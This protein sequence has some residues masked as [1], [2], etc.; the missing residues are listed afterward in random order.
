MPD[1]QI[2]PREKRIKHFQ[3]DCPSEV[4]FSDWQPNNRV[5]TKQLIMKNVSKQSLTLTYKL[6]ELA[7]FFTPYPNQINLP[8]GMEYSI[9]VSFQPSAP[10]EL[11]SCL[12]FH[13]NQYNEDFK[14]QLRGDLPLLSAKTN[15]TPN[16]PVPTAVC[17][18]NF[19]DVPLKNDG[20]VP[21]LFKFVFSEEK[22]PFSVIPESG[23]INEGEQLM[24]RYWFKPE[25]SGQIQDTVQLTIKKV[26]LEAMAKVGKIDYQIRLNAISKFPHFRIKIDDIYNDQLSFINTTVIDEK[27]KEVYL[28]N[29][30]PVRASFRINA[31]T[32][33]DKPYSQVT[34]TP[35]SGIVEP[36]EKV[37]LKVTYRP[38]FAAAFYQVAGETLGPQDGSAEYSEAQTFIQYNPQDMNIKMK[39]QILAKSV[40][41]TTFQVVCSG[42]PVDIQISHT[43][44]DLGC[45]LCG[46]SA[47]KSIY[48]KNNSKSDCPYE[49]T[50]EGL[51]NQQGETPAAIVTTQSIEAVELDDVT[52]PTQR[53]LAKFPLKVTP[54]SGIAPSQINTTINISLNL[55]NFTC[56]SQD[57]LD[58]NSDKKSYIPPQPVSF[59]LQ[60]KTPGAPVQFI[61]VTGTILPEA[62]FDSRPAPLTMDYSERYDLLRREYTVDQ[63]LGQLVAS[64]GNPPLP[65]NSPLYDETLL[66]FET[67]YS[68]SQHLSTQALNKMI[69][70]YNYQDMESKPQAN[71]LLPSDALMLELKGKL[72]HCNK[73]PAVI[74]ERSYNFGYVAAGQEKKHI[75]TIYNTSE[76]LEMFCAFTGASHKQCISIEFLGLS[77]FDEVNSRAELTPSTLEQSHGLEYRTVLTKGMVVRIPPQTYGFFELTFSPDQNEEVYFTKFAV[78][79]CHQPLLLYRCFRHAIVGHS[80]IQ[81]LNVLGFSRPSELP[82]LTSS[83]PVVSKPVVDMNIKLPPAG[84]GSI[85]RTTFAFTNYGSTFMTVNL[86]ELT[87]NFVHVYPEV[88]GLEPKQTCVVSLALAFPM[89]ALTNKEKYGFTFLQQSQNSVM[90]EDIIIF[91]VNGSSESTVTL[92]MLA[93]CCGVD[94]V[95]EKVQEE[96]Q[97]IQQLHE[98]P[99]AT[100]QM[101]P[102]SLGSESSRILTFINKA[103]LPVQFYVNTTNQRDQQLMYMSPNDLLLSGCESKE[104][105]YV[106][107]ASEKFLKEG[108]YTFDLNVQVTIPKYYCLPTPNNLV[109]RALNYKHDLS[110]INAM[111]IQT[112]V[113]RRTVE[114]QPKT[115][116]L[117]NVVPYTS[118]D[119][120]IQIYNS[121]HCSI[122][123]TLEIHEIMN[124]MTPMEF[125]K[126]NKQLRKYPYTTATDTGDYLVPNLYNKL[127]NTE[128]VMDEQQTKRCPQIY[129][130]S[131]AGAMI[132]PHSSSQA[133][134]TVFPLSCRTVR[135]KIYAKIVEI[136]STDRKY[137]EVVKDLE[138]Q[139]VYLQGTVQAFNQYQN[140]DSDKM[141]E[142]RLECTADYPRFYISDISS[143]K[144]ASSQ[145][146]D[147]LNVD[148]INEFLAGEVSLEERVYSTP[149]NNRDKLIDKLL[150]DKE[151]K[152]FDS[153]N[154]FD[155]VSIHS[156]ARLDI[157]PVE[158]KDPATKFEL[159]EPPPENLDAEYKSKE[160][161]LLE[162][163][164]LVL[165]PDNLNP[166]KSYFVC[167]TLANPSDIP[168]H[169][170]FE[171]PNGPELGDCPWVQQLPSQAQQRTMSLLAR[172]IYSVSPQ[173]IYLKPHEKASLTINYAHI[174]EGIHKLIVLAKIAGGRSFFLHLIGSTLAEF[175]PALIAPIEQRLLP[176]ALGE[177]IPVRQ[178]M[179]IQ[180]PGNVYVRYQLVN[181]RLVF[182]QD[183]APDSSSIQQLSQADNLLKILNPTGIIPPE[184]GTQL[185]MQ[186]TPQQV[187]MVHMRFDL[188]IQRV[189]EQEFQSFKQTLKYFPGECNCDLPDESTNKQP[190]YAVNI[191]TVPDTQTYQQIDLFCYGFMK[192]SSVPTQVLP[193]FAKNGSPKAPACGA[194]SLQRVQNK[195]ENRLMGQRGL[196]FGELSCGR[197]VL[198]AVPTFGYSSALVELKCETG[199]IEWEVMD[200]FGG[201]SNLQ[202]K[203]EPNRGVLQKGQKTQILIQCFTGPLP[204]A[205]LEDIPFKI[206]NKRPQTQNVQFGSV[207][208][209]QNRLP[210]VLANTV[211]SAARISE[212]AILQQFD[213]SQQNRAG[214]DQETRQQHAM[215]YGVEDMVC[216]HKSGPLSQ[217][218]TYPDTDVLWLTVMLHSH[219]ADYLS[220]YGVLQNGLMLNRSAVQ[221]K[222]IIQKQ[223]IGSDLG[224]EEQQQL[225][226]LVALALRGAVN[227]MISDK[228]SE[229]KLNKAAARAK[230]D[231][232]NGLQKAN[233]FQ[234]EVEDYVQV[235]DGQK[236][237]VI[238]QAVGI[239]EF[240]SA[241]G[242]G[243]I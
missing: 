100:I 171:L 152:E 99:V 158:K 110:R 70:D 190:P 107:K 127:Y 40:V 195:S 206:I 227:K 52:R 68:Q 225:E 233:F 192:N 218:M 2:L 104:F 44:V 33:L 166:D 237:N 13:V 73:Y 116:N 77:Q 148:Q 122:C 67:E 135:A 9:T 118:V 96:Q 131:G 38:A 186:F 97:I 48:I 120:P 78:F 103:L 142:C 222:E 144:I 61:H 229:A 220:D 199:K 128:S 228:Q 75:V 174:E 205:F 146:R 6:P 54:C 181:Q 139:S 30:S 163:F 210:A 132:L 173:E 42:Q 34:V 194:V 167:L 184:S 72:G 111:K 133:V 95:M 85:T 153:G 211:A 241:L 15:L 212:T 84:P 113:T 234:A 203:I 3:I 20:E 216:E 105:S 239:D 21:F 169:I 102:V 71:S 53:K 170:S 43:K 196:G 49:I 143:P 18:Q 214:L 202:I 45:V 217:Y 137:S 27:T 29:D 168:C 106:L 175:E 162:E 60:Y 114:L 41:S 150:K 90:Y 176:V 88:F 130:R 101:A 109:S 151:L 154:D 19:I 121:S 126:D 179:R 55:L 50:C 80:Y 10:V 93:V 159:V 82:A 12:I 243:L 208:V 209:N 215:L 63:L 26:D 14:I 201:N 51:M 178:Y 108:P 62:E 22:T 91:N 221:I 32:V 123:Y 83:M 238:E 16:F 231:A 98:T 87:N 180:N 1:L 66:E 5:Y 164:P 39:F 242:E 165:G 92:N 4:V 115:V 189:S 224:D 25:E 183:E 24:V 125:E 157:K 240:L 232:L 191:P 89:D 35:Q 141:F 81:E 56:K 76:L 31:D 149:C 37:I 11:E 57:L 223:Q 185:V 28:V 140:V 112:S 226:Q 213:P 74:S 188:C 193:S 200:I 129:I 235:V 69:K 124:D 134:I 172:K 160:E 197:L 117:Q 230:R 86:S 219:R 59:Y 79:C 23:L 156:N 46:S 161:M 155:D 119:V 7:N 8:I 136:D 47:Q 204:A 36:N 236:D 58:Q 198:G 207:I 177:V 147:I 64:G 138:S 145:L 182:E 17:E 94:L 65:Q 187:G